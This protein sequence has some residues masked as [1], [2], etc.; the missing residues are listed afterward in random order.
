MILYRVLQVRIFL[1][2]TWSLFLFPPFSV[3]LC[4]CLFSIFF[5]P[6]LWCQLLASIMLESSCHFQA[7]KRNSVCRF[8]VALANTHCRELMKSVGTLQQINC[9]HATVDG[10]LN[11]LEMVTFVHA[12]SLI[13]LC[14]SSLLLGV[15]CSFPVLQVLS[16]ILSLT[17]RKNVL[18]L[19]LALLTMSME[20]S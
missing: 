11:K 19:V 1:K 12:A 5:F 6:L 4:F 10:S 13:V 3:S 20:I 7:C 18:Y 2:S 16:G 8:V 17:S 9:L 14:L 15:F